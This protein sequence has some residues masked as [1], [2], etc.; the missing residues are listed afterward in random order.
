MTKRILALL[1]ALA[2]LAG[3]CLA[4]SGFA[5][6]ETEESPGL[7]YEELEIYLSG[8]VKAALADPELDVTQTAQDGHGWLWAAFRGGVLEIE[9]EQLTE[10]SIAFYAELS[11][12]Q[13]DPR[14]LF[15]GDS[16]E[17]LLSVY[18]NDNPHLLGSY[19]DATL[20]VSGEKPEVCVGWLL[21]NGQ[22]AELA[23]Y[24]VYAWR[25]DG[26]EC[27]SIRFDLDQNVIT[28]IRIGPRNLYTEAEALEEIRDIADLQE[29]TAYFAY[30]QSES[31]Q[32]LAPFQREDL[33]WAPVG[34]I[35]PSARI[36]FLDMTAEAALSA[37]GP[38]A[39]DEWME[40]A[41]EW[42]R[43][44]YWDGMSLA[45]VYDASRHFLRVDS[46]TVSADVLEGPRGVR[47]GDDL[48]TV[49]D[50][51][52]H[53][54]GGFTDGGMALYGGEELPYGLLAYDAEGS[55]LTYALSLEEGKTVLWYLTFIGAR[56]DSMRL[57][58]R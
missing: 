40:D 53:G 58:L 44:L 4:E 31:G 15:L 34:G 17:E 45:L 39:A 14:G 8:L 41:G 43:V 2:M 11:S 52:R 29:I 36:D 38:A 5:L 57:L 24:T 27:L 10:D 37:F 7:T 22:R 23:V 47:I 18:P 55:A 20:Y 32:D 56:L 54:E 19:Y 12:E 42:L 16:L 49:I 26:V 35:D 46:L 48:D 50:R 3:V 1:L 30:P 9:E 28:G 33:I 6:P 21:R 13:A 51:F 25:E